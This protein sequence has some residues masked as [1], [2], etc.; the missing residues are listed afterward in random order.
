V[1]PGTRG[2]DPGGRFAGLTDGALVAVG[3]SDVPRSL[4]GMSEAREDLRRLVEELREDQVFVALLEVQR[5]VG[6]PETPVWPPPWFGAVTSGLSDTSE[7]V[8]ELLADGFSC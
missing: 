6:T 4:R 2:A 7:R 5:L 8:D 3:E 1:R